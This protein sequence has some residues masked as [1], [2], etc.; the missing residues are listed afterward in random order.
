MDD[1]DDKP[2][3]TPPDSALLFNAELEGHRI[4]PASLNGDPLRDDQLLWVDIQGDAPLP[5]VL[6]RAGLVP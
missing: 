5:A 3:N 6:E 4:D 2:G 1:H